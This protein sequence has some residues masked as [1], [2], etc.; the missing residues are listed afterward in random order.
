MFHSKAK[1]SYCSPSLQGD[2]S[3]RVDSPHSNSTA[4]IWLAS[5]HMVDAS[6]LSPE[7][8]NSKHIFRS[9][10]LFLVQ[11]IVRQGSQAPT[12]LLPVEG[13]QVIAATLWGRNTRGTFASLTPPWAGT[14]GKAFHKEVPPAGG[15]AAGR[16]SAGFHM[17]VAI[18]KQNTVIPWYTQSVGSRTSFQTGEFSSAFSLPN[19]IHKLNTTQTPCK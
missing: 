5:F 12:T 3:K 8:Q 16:W 11:C 2:L 6:H 9:T 18:Q 19:D 13:T 4:F 10:R 15:H 7:L 1:C 14:A 17:L